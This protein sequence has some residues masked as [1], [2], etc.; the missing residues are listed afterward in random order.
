MKING[1]MIFWVIPVVVAEISAHI[2]M[3]PSQPADPG[4]I[5]ELSFPANDKSWTLRSEVYDDVAPSLHCN[6]G[7]ISDVGS[8]EDLIGRVSFF[9]WDST[10]TGNTLEA[11]K[12]LPEQCMGSIGMH[13][14]EIH[15]TREL[16]TAAGTLHFDSTQFRPQG[17][18]RTVHIFKCVW[19]SGFPE[20][21]LRGDLL[22]SNGQELRQ[23]RLAAAVSRFQPQHTRIIMGG[24]FGMPTEELAWKRFKNTIHSQLRWTNS[25]P[26][27]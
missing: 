22:G 26:S 12:H 21:T 16:G 3:N 27:S 15:P 20:S 2:W 24:I 6:G 25:C 9:Q 18:G 5:L 14:E 10:N 11:F 8:E 1:R 13:L 7:W 17:G 19:V 23:L 4:G